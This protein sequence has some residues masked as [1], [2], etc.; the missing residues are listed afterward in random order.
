MESMGYDIAYDKPN[1]ANPVEAQTKSHFEDLL[2]HIGVDY[3]SYY[4]RRPGV[5]PLY[6]NITNP[7]DASQ[8]IPPNLMRALEKAAGRERK[9]GGEHYTREYSLRQWVEDIKGGDQY[10]STQVPTKALQILQDFGYDGIKELGSKG[11]P[12]GQDRQVNWIAFRPDQIKSVF[13]KTPT[14]DAAS[15]SGESGPFYSKLHRTIESKMPGRANKQQI[16]ATLGKE[17]GVKAEELKWSGLE[18]YL[19]DKTKNSTDK[20]RRIDKQDVLDYLEMS[21]SIQFQEHTRRVGDDFDGEI[22]GRGTEDVNLT[23]A[24]WDHRYEEMYDRFRESEEEYYIS[25]M[26]VQSLQRAI[27]EGHLDGSDLDVEELA[28]QY[29]IDPEDVYDDLYVVY[30]YGYDELLPGDYNAVT[31]RSTPE[32]FATE[33]RAQDTIYQYAS[34]RASDMDDY[35]VIEDM[36]RMYGTRDEAVDAE[37]GGGQDG[38]GGTAYMDYAFRG[39][40]DYTET[41]LSF[42]KPLHM[43]SS[44]QPIT[45][46]GFTVEPSGEIV[47]QS[48]APV[49]AMSQ[50]QLELA[51]TGIEGQAPTALVEMLIKGPDGK[52]LEVVDA[53]RN[54]P[55][56][57]IIRDYVRQ[58]NQERVATARDRQS[59]EQSYTTGEHDWLGEVDN[60]VLHTRAQTFPDDKGIKG[61]NIEEIQS[62]HHKQA[63]EKGYK[64]DFRQLPNERLTQLKQEARAF[65]DANVV[66]EEVPNPPGTP[67]GTQVWK[68][69]RLEHNGVLYEFNSYQADQ[70]KSEIADKLVERHPEFVEGQKARFGVMDAPFRTH[71]AYMLHAFKRELRKAVEAGLPWISWIDGRESADRYSVRKVVET[72]E[73]S[74]AAPAGPDQ[75]T[76]GIK[77]SVRDSDGNWV[78]E[79]EANQPKEPQYELKAFREGDSYP[80]A[81]YKVT[82]NELTKYMGKEVAERLI[83]APR[84]NGTRTLT[85]DQLEVGGQFHKK[86]YDGILPKA[87]KKFIKPYGAKVGVGKLAT[88][89]GQKLVHRVDIT[90]ALAHAA[91]TGDMTLFSGEAGQ[92]LYSTPISK[93]VSPDGTIPMVHIQ[94]DEEE[95]RYLVVGPDGK[96]LYKN[97]NLRAATRNIRRIKRN[98]MPTFTDLIPQDPPRKE[99][100]AETVGPNGDIISY[101]EAQPER[102]RNES[103]GQRLEIRTP[104]DAEMIYRGVRKQ[105]SPVLGMTDPMEANTGSPAEDSAN[106]LAPDLKEPTNFTDPAA[107]IA[108]MRKRRPKRSEISEKGALMRSE[109]DR[110]QEARTPLSSDEGFSGETNNWQT[111][112]ERR[113]ARRRRAV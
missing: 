105:R 36:D 111:R 46:E 106:N 87:V 97:L 75:S 31:R 92:A 84:K 91:M 82:E 57:E 54:K 60:Y 24:E 10:W 17:P 43:E 76:A 55:H 73:L 65:V 12:E 70:I 52:L 2:D 41:V 94:Q 64:T 74:D 107:A 48:G 58:N 18:Q 34:D 25:E 49:A 89:E 22:E 110:A 4:Q 50:E 26:E 100:V 102:G 68:K 66:I 3:R 62:D 69:G 19:D 95:D 96:T 98:G 112:R 77:I 44:F 14:T 86:I 104:E 83:A 35:H 59:S 15:F 78:S 32:I 85:G 23:P 29:A 27:D 72:L 42:L 11:G 7:I 101:S 108:A 28:Q 103:E 51:M 79:K 47:D 93:N 71:E 81:R 63:I 1:A 40:E 5:F 99:K 67:E 21:G 9:Q 90:E 37:D 61:H 8:P 30:Q 113:L 109:S 6:L 53:P 88:A 33:D 45:G 13:N 16:M 56:A 39:G 20:K 80:A 38:R